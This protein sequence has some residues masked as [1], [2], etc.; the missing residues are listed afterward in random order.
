MGTHTS[1]PA[2]AGPGPGPGDPLPLSPAVLR[3]L[4]QALGAIR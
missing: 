1:M 3:E 4:R 2:G